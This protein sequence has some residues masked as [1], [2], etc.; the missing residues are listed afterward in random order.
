MN[1]SKLILFLLFLMTLLANISLPYSVEL[2]MLF[3]GLK[4][5]PD[6]LVPLV[7]LS[8]RSSMAVSVPAFSGVSTT[9]RLCAT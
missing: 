2:S 4:D 8:K 9:Y 6:N 3:L 7:S 1:P 5:F